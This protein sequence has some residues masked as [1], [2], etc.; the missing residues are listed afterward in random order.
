MKPVSLDANQPR[1]FYRGGSAIARFR[2]VP[3]RDEHMP[4]DWIASTTAMFG[5]GD[6][7][8]S[9]LPDGRV[10]RDAVTEDAEAWL[11]SDHVARFGSDSALLV[12]LL[13]A[14]ERLPVHC[15]PSQAFAGRHLGCAHGK[16]EAWIV[17]EA[18]D[19]NAVI[20]LGF[21]E[22][23][24][25]DTLAE[26]VASR[27]RAALV[28]ALN[29]IP[30]QP[31]DAV[32][33]PAGVPHAIGAG[34]FVVELQEPSDLS[35]MIERAG[36]E[37]P[38]GA[39]LDLG[40]GDRLALSCVDR[41]S[42]GGGRLARVHLR[43]GS[44]VAHGASL[45]PAEADPFFRADRWRFDGSESLEPSFAVLVVTAGSGALRA[46]DAE[47]PLARGATILVPHGAGRSELAGDLDLIRC[48]PPAPGSTNEEVL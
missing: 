29:V 10:L 28:D 13:D 11:G 19:D 14:G 12:K 22:E 7:G 38:Q 27:D 17:L 42:W 39:V 18:S 2:G 45:L 23:V 20:Y 21:R 37:F 34:V 16:T 40:L 4:E 31:G 26:W 1:H 44:E 43:H 33:V 30:V 32:L 25:M 8:L 9:R 24:G 46:A 36:F 35:I 41:T 15:H 48:R 3:A 5:R 47:L 6:D